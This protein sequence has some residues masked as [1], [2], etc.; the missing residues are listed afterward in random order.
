MRYAQ[1]RVYPGTRP[2]SPVRLDEIPDDWHCT[3]V[4]RLVL[5]PDRQVTGGFWELKFINAACL[6]HA[7]L[8]SLS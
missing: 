6:R 7:R 8:P 4:Y 3:W 2:L 5:G 1:L